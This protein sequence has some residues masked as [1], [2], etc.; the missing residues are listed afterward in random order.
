M[1]AIAIIPAR[2]GSRRIPKKNIRQFFGKP[3]IAYSIE[4]AKA[5]GLF[6]RIVVSTD[7]KEI[8]NVAR[9]LGADAL[10][11]NP[12]LARDDVGTQE[13]TRDALT[14]LADGRRYACC[15]Y[16]CAPLLMASDLDYACRQIHFGDAG[17]SVGDF[18]FAV[19]TDPL[20]DAGQ[21]YLGPVRSFLQRRPLVSPDSFM[22]PIPES[23]VC[24]INTP[25][26]WN[27]ALELYSRLHNMPVDPAE[28]IHEVGS[29][30]DSHVAD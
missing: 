9:E 25:A 13:V 5:S 19:G 2:G 14:Y 24:D 6:D 18:A 21:F 29:G 1:S 30:L 15:I 4:A 16:P 22:I 26:D 17:V 8:E 12:A 11:R 3:I 7:D 27:R 20:R 28:V 23:R 10:I